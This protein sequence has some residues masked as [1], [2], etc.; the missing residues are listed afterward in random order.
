[1][2]SRRLFAWLLAVVSLGLTATGV[3]FAALSSS[4]DSGALALNDHPPT[5]ARL[6]MTMDTGNGIAM[7]GTGSID[8]VHNAIDLQVAIP[9]VIT[10]VNAELRFINGHLY[11]GNASVSAL[12]NGQTATKSWMQL[13]QTASTLDLTGLSLTMLKPQL[14]H[15]NDGARVSNENGLVVYTKQFTAKGNEHATVKLYTEPAGQIAGLDI[16]VHLK[17]VHLHIAAQMTAY[18]AP[19]HITA[20]PAK[21]IQTLP[22]KDALQQLLG[23]LGSGGSLLPSVAS[24]LSGSSL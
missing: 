11:V 23:G 3:T 24:I 22:S 10:T 17:G 13:N 19:V 21:D 6:T 1:M 9:L 16:A 7:N 2:R 12:N 15:L 18:N 8:F 20:P 14:G 4:T 5:T